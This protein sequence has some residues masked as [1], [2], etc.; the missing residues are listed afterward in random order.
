MRKQRK[1][2]D[3]IMQDVPYD[4]VFSDKGKVLAEVFTLPLWQLNDG[5]VNN[6]KKKRAK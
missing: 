3:P 2:I 1:R 5:M 4:I 6:P